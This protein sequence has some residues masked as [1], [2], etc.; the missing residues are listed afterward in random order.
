MNRFFLGKTFDDFLIRPQKGIVKTRRDVSL[1]MPLSKNLKISLPITG[2]NMD[3]VT[4]AKMA[5]T[6]AIEGGF[7]FL[8][9]N[10]SISEQAEMV[11]VVKKHHSHI[12]ENPL[13]IS[14]DETVADAIRLTEEHHVSGL[15]IEKE[16]GS[17]ILVG[18]LS[19][20]DLEFA[21]NVKAFNEKAAGFHGP[22]WP[23]TVAD[24]S[25]SM[26]AAEKVMLDSR[27]EKLPLV[28]MTD[29]NMHIEG[30]ITL[31]DLRAA[32]QKP[33]SSKDAKGRLLVGAAIGATG[34][35]LERAAELI[36]QGVDCILMDIAHAHSEVMGK[37]IESFHAKFG[38]QVDLI[39][40]NVATSEAVKFLLELGVDAVK[41]GLGP[42]RGCRTRLETGFGVP[43]VQAVREAFMAVKHWVDEGNEFIPVIADGG[44]KTDKDIFM[45]IACGASSVMLG[46]M[47]AG[48]DESPGDKI[49]NPG[50]SQW[51]KRY[52]GM[53]SPE[54]VLDNLALSGEQG[55]NTPAEGQE[56]RVPY[57]GSVVDVLQRIKGHLRS[58]V[59]Y[60]GT[61]SL[62]E[63]WE[64]I[65]ANPEEYLI[66]LSEASRKESF[67]R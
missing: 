15:L 5:K 60:S 14:Q 29:G 51:F 18:I 25:I 39:C 67:E 37:A 53:T 52:R 65:P 22:N 54:A 4:A 44:M 17:G 45:A 59:S 10:C 55:M 16:K 20:R 62:N 12:V 6:L 2:A 58:S 56:D 61:T 28:R 9:R 8:H 31:K 21:K 26:D 33:Y 64:K 36:E 19:R 41:I 3:T 11:R 23:L 27:V 66:P 47:L 57:V 63:A 7:G 13:I 32:K 34:D 43:Q 50:T 48:T 46:S 40:G 1:A 30:L 49:Q 35:Y 38:K 24:P 42:G